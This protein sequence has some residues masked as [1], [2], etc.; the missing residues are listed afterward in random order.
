[1]GRGR[2]PKR[3]GDGKRVVPDRIGPRHPTEPMRPRPA[4]LTRASSK[5]EGWTW[6]GLVRLLLR[7]ARGLG[8]SA[9]E[10]ED[11]VQ[12]AVEAT[13]RD[14]AWYDPDR[15]PRWRIISPQGGP[16]PVAGKARPRTGRCDVY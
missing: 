11:L 9:E 7:H 16:E 2:G 4:T 1:V 6:G 8:A 5:P 14:P 13:V 3:E 12:E 15:G 10:A